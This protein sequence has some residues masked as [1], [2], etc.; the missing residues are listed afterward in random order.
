MK[1]IKANIDNIE[2]RRY[3]TFGCNK[4]DRAKVQYHGQ[5]KHYYGLESPGVGTY[6]A[7]PSRVGKTLF[8]NIFSSSIILQEWIVI[9]CP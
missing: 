4:D 7:D 6:K 8:D 2:P 1:S 9:F 3:S 5:E